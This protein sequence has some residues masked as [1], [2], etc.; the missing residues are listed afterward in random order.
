[1]IALGIISGFI[2][3]ALALGWPGAFAGGFVGLIVVLA[4]RSRTEALERQS[5]PQISPLAQQ[6]LRPAAS[7]AALDD[8][9]RFPL[10]L[11]RLTAIE[12]RLETLERHAGIATTR[13]EPEPA[14]LAPAFDAT[15]SGALAP[16]IPAMPMAAMPPSRASAPVADAPATDA[17]GLAEFVRAM[18]G[19]LAPPAPVMPAA[20]SV[21]ASPQPMAQPSTPMDSPPREPAPPARVNPLWA[22]FT[23]GNALTRIGVVI[24]FFGVGF[25]LKY[26][27]EFV[28]IPI[29]V[30]LLGVALVGGVLIGLGGWLARTRPGYGLSL[31]G[32]GAGILYLTAFAAF[33]LYGVL[34]AIPAFV[35]LVAIAVLTVALAV[36]A[37]SQALAGLAI[38]G[39]FLAP[40]L[41]ATSSGSPTRL[42]GY[43]AILNAA[44]FA[45]AWVRAWRGLNVLGFIFTFALGLFWGERFY[46]PEHFAAVEPFLVLFFLFYVAIAVLYA[47][48][49]PL[50]AKAPVDALL[51]FGVPLIGFALQ[52]NL[53]YDTRYGVAWSALCMAVVYGVLAAALYRRPEP[54]LSLLARA[55]FVLAVIF[56]TIAIPFAADPRWTSA[57]WAL[58][59][60][61]VYWIGCRQRQPLARA[62]ALLL[63]VGAAIAFVAAGLEEGERLFLNATFLGTTMIALAALATAF[64]ADRQHAAITATER[65][66]AP[67]LA[68]WG[69]AWWYGGG[70][71]ELERALPA[72]AEG[73]AILAY[74][75]ATVIAALLLRR[76]PRRPRIAWFGVA[77]LPAMVLVA[78]VDWDRLRTTLL[79]YGWLVWP[80]AWATHWWV[81]RAADALRADDPAT[82]TSSSWTAGFLKHAH[83][84][85]VIAAVA[86]VAWESSEWVGRVFPD[87]TVWMPCAAAWPAI[88]Y[89]GLIVRTGEWNAWPLRLYRDAYATSAPTAIAALLAVWFALVNVISPG[90]AEPLPY[91]P[92]AN[93]LDVTLIAALAAVFMWARRTAH[94]SERTL[95]QWWGAAVFLLLNAIVFRAVHQ[96]LDV[97]W[98][99]SALLASKP[100]Q[101]ALTLTWT[102]TALPLMLIAGKRSI[103]P[104]WM[105]GA[106]LLAIVVVKLFLVDLG[107]LS[108]LSRVVAFLGV[109]V[110]LL[111]IGYL[112]P[113]PPSATAKGDVPTR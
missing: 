43:F 37:D 53:V 9:T 6:P 98:R 8:A 59:A 11:R 105:V 112:A 94:V 16:D 47:K 79:V 51:V 39:G 77:L 74:V 34:P 27:A 91:V 66:L 64:V 83:T 99:L 18:D 4:W 56:A 48:R 29:E 104:L 38:A 63:Q 49:G 45:L 55:F 52:A 84:A 88:L 85:S 7:A 5:R 13:A 100:L 31:E 25:L 44:I 92:L 70:V 103:R 46:R 19:T 24:L 28:T 73:N 33:K 65:A 23:G 60:A 30:K 108:G 113:L 26:F 58:E 3:G 15:P 41:V 95:Y 42:L 17:P 54:G 61:G 21:A 69:F 102:A 89:L 20:R 80:I 111:I 67:L 68:A 97:P 71:L 36:R 10:V 93:P 32:A 101:A 72:R 1:M 96:W 107:A 109:G 110:L 35:L 78:F 76:W 14:P 87:G 82:G 40:F 106:G 12:R 62:F 50:Q 22:W 86:W 2:V 81:L 57:W 90:G 75:V